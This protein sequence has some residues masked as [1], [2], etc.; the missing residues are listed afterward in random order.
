VALTISFRKPGNEPEEWVIS[1]SVSVED[2]DNE[3]I[4]A[5]LINIME[6]EFMSRFE[7]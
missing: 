1:K 6:T 7:D 2:L 4:L 5:G 3:P